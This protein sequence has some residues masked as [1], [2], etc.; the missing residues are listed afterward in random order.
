MVGV[1]SDSG[2][3][4][5]HREKIFDSFYR[6]EKSR[7]RERDDQGGVAL[8]LAIARGLVEANGG[9]IW[10]GR[11]WERALHFSLSFQK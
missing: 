4:P 3:D 8:G 10:V 5:Q 2:I 9:E 7:A 6:G 1:D 11:T